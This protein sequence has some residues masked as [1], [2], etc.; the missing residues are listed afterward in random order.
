MKRAPEGARRVRLNNGGYALVDEQDFERVSAY[1]WFANVTRHGRGY[2]RT[3]TPVNPR[4]SMHRL[5]MNAPP[6]LVVDHI[7]HDKLDNRRCNLRLCTA[8]ENSLNRAPKQAG[9]TT[10]RY[11]GV[12]HHTGRWR[13]VIVVEGRRIWLGRYKTEEEAARAY[14]TA[15]RKH[16]GAFAAPNF[17]EG[18]TAA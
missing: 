11:S 15:A 2:V 12:S 5:V 13:A 17:P 4:I 10:S 1:R 3:S 18:E 14:D 8:R 9:K 6:G 16:F 7:N